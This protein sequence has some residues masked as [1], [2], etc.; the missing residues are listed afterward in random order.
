MY[1]TP[2]WPLPRLDSAAVSCLRPVPE[3]RGLCRSLAA[4]AAAGMASPVSNVRLARRA[5]GRCL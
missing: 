2:P 1:A 3:L 4:L 5:V